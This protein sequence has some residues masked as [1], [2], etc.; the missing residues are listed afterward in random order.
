MFDIAQKNQYRDVSLERYQSHEIRRIIQ[1]VF[2][3]IFYV[4]FHAM[5]G[6]D[7]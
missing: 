2:I 7:D 1:F 5:G 4:E 3:Y 6:A